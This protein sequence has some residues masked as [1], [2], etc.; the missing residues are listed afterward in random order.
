MINWPESLVVELAA[1]RCI[2][3]LGA[4]C[5]M[6]ACRPDNPD[7]HPPNW[8]DF[9]R[10]LLEECNRGGDDDRAKAKELL[11]SQQ[12]L[13]CAEILRSTCI[14]PPDYNRIVTRTFERYR[15]T[16]VHRLVEQLDQK[17]VITT[18]FDT[19][20]E[21]HCRQGDATFGY[22]VMNYY[23][24]GLIN[25]LRSPTRVIVKAH[26]CATAPERTILS[27]SD[28]FKGRSTAPAFFKALE[29]LFLTHTLLFLGYS[30]GDPDIQLL[31]E[32]ST[33]TAASEHPHY[34][35][36]PLGIHAAIRAAFHRTYNIEILEFDPTD[37]FAEFIACLQD[38]TARVNETRGTQP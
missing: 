3:F 26:G 6:S 35:V 8:S 25:R 22:A 17:I 36:M 12:Y 14:H 33:I 23:D 11:G 2:L 13:D 38:L 9:L 29:S 5:S 32:N 7:G 19:I 34:A 20:Y 1:R 30:V 27:K 28:F 21:D 15:P 4:G 10:L 37:N 18:N 24:Q 31:L 16:E